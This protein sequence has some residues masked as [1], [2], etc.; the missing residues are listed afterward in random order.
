MTYFA[1]QGTIVRR[2]QASGS[3]LPA[4]VS[5]IFD[6]V[7]LVG[8]VKLPSNVRTTTTF[9]T[10]DSAD[11]RSVG[12]G[13][14]QRVVSFRLVFDPTDSV[15]LSMLA[16]SKSASSTTA[17]RNWRQIL[18]DSGAYQFDHVGYISKWEWED[19]ENEKEVAAT[20]EISVD[21]AVTETA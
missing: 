12:G 6:T 2:G 21:G 5:D 1:G 17:R 8:T 13:F 18:P 4:P 16:E 14:E 7:N 10:L 19:V 20:I 15:H 9:K 3:S 11:P